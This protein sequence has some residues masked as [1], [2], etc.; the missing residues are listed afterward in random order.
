LFRQSRFDGDD[1]VTDNFPP[2]LEPH[3]KS[4]SKEVPSGF[5]KTEPDKWGHFN[6]RCSSKKLVKGELRQCKKCYRHDRFPVAEKH[7]H[8]FEELCFLSAQDIGMEGLK[9][10]LNQITVKL[11]GE[12]NLSINFIR[13]PFF[14]DFVYGVIDIGYS[15]SHFTNAETLNLTDMFPTASF[16]K[17]RQ[18]FISQSEQAHMERFEEMQQFTNGSLACD[19]GTIDHKKYFDLFLCSPGELLM[20]IPFITTANH[21]NTKE[22]I[23]SEIQTAIKIATENNFIIGGIVANNLIGQQTTIKE[24][25]E[26][27]DCLQKG[28]INSPCLCHCLNLLFNDLQKVNGRFKTSIEILHKLAKFFNS[29]SEL[30]KLPYRFPIH[31]LTR[32]N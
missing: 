24:V 16:F 17:L 4:R 18:L 2:L 14:K 20:N 6:Y 26:S 1:Q 23:T 3:S 30:K 22:M 12:G 9:Q 27:T 29:K 19:A 5:E 28:I 11:A 32:W 7:Q 13:Q 21:K 25:I 15:L 31:V 10:K 8:V